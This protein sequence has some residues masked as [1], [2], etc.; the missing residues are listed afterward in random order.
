MF[1]LYT[2]IVHEFVLIPRTVLMQRAYYLQI[3]ILG[4]LT[5][6]IN[7]AAKELGV[8][9]ISNERTGSVMIFIQ[10]FILQ[11]QYRSKI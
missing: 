3:N 5:I 7:I 9:I 1:T 4:V 2:K 10:E 11:R 6:P 8:K